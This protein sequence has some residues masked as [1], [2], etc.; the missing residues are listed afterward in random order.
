MPVL[1]DKNAK[2]VRHAGADVAC[3]RACPNCAGPTATRLPRYSTPEWH[4]VRCADCGFV[5][6]GNP[7]AYQE[8]VETFAWEKTSVMEKERRRKRRP[9]LS[10]LDR[11]SRWRLGLLG[12]DRAGFYRRLFRQGR[13]LDVGCA[14][15][16][17]V[18]EPFIPFGIEISRS[19]YEKA[20][21]TM[22]ARGGKAIHGPAAEAIVEFPDRYFAGIIMRSVLEHETQPKRVLTHVAR[23][24]EDGGKAYIRV[25]NFG[26][27]NRMVIGGNWCGL[28]HPDH[29]NYFTVNSLCRM[30]GDCGLSVK[31]LTPL[32]LPFNDNINAVLSRA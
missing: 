1:A 3:S 15:G 6:L 5:Y 22:Q 14:T 8:L 11:N 17:K 18:P 23:V 7:P 29:V 9:L 32:L 10:W 28:R 20:H 19:L 21:A 13:V 12:R 4:V 30:A 27:V 31:L 26:S 16:S 25:P 2:A 24:L